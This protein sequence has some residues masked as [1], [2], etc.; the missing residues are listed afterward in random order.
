[1]E[2]RLI[3]FLLILTS[4]G[5]IALIVMLVAI[6][7]AD[8]VPTVWV[9]E[10]LRLEVDMWTVHRFVILILIISTITL[11]VVRPFLP[12]RRQRGIGYIV[13]CASRGLSSQADL[14]HARQYLNLLFQKGVPAFRV[15]ALLPDGCLAFENASP[16]F[17]LPRLEIPLEYEAYPGCIGRFTTSILDEVF[18]VIQ[19]WSREPLITGISLLYFNHCEDDSPDV[20]ERSN[21]KVQEL[22]GWAV[23]SDKPFLAVLDSPAS[24]ALAERA[25]RELKRSGWP[26]VDAGFLTSGR[27]ANYYSA[28]IL[29]TE[30]PESLPSGDGVQF[31]IN[32]SM[33][34]RS[35]SLELAYKLGKG[36]A[37]TLVG[38]PGRMNVAGEEMKNGFEAAFHCF[39]PTMRE[40][41]VRFFFPWAPIGIDEMSLVRPNVCFRDVIPRE[42]IGDFFDDIGTF[43]P[44]RPRPRITGWRSSTSPSV[45]AW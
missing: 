26:R 35:L 20:L 10:A 45:M 18:S 36:D 11:V 23:Q 13:A 41:P 17:G 2:V 37:T 40:R 43:G 31:K 28:V 6:L 30:T 34:S 15:R 27:G 3:I 4:F 14:M 25:V 9:V 38:L 22:E 21:L 39:G 32:H 44:I 5:Q 33:F 42:E 29:S 12:A 19:D 24:T 8:S 16:H 7:S 1:M